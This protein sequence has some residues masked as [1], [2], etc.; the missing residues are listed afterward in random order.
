MPGQ[1][2]FAVPGN[3]KVFLVQCGKL[4]APCRTVKYFANQVNLAGGLKLRHPAL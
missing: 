1:R 4:Q 3:I 2:A